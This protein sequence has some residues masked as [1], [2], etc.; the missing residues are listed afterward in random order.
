LSIL[1]F[2]RS[3]KT[4]S[5][6]YLSAIGDRILTAPQSFGRIITI[7]DN[8]IAM[9]QLDHVLTVN[10]AMTS[11]GSLID[12]TNYVNMSD[13]QWD[14]SHEYWKPKFA[15]GDKITLQITTIRSEI[16]RFVPSPPPQPPP[17]PP[18]PRTIR[19]KVTV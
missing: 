15:S 7:P 5:Y 12:H 18:P 8:E 13:F 4:K 3:K 14:L 2:T 16:P 19:S 9:V 10:G 11:T 1:F 17:P 6:F